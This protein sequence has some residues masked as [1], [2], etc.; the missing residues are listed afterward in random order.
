MTEPKPGSAAPR[1]AWLTRLRFLLIAWVVLYHLDLTLKVHEVLP[2]L[3]PVLL[4]GYLG[5]DGFFLL[6]GFALWLGYAGRPPA[7]ARGVGRFLL[8]RI[9]KIWPLHA[10]AL[11]GLAA[12]VALASASGAAIRH[13]ERFGA[14]DF[15]LQLLLVNAW[16]T[17]G[18]HA[19]NYPS[20][21][22]SAIF[23]G[24]L[25]FPPLLRAMLRLPRPAVPAVALATLA[26]LAALSA[27]RPGIG[28]NWTIHLGL[29]RFGLEFVLGLALARLA[30]EGRL[31]G[32]SWMLPGAAL[33]LC[34]GLLLRQD[35]LAATGL[36]G[37]IAGLWLLGRARPEAVG[38][39]PDLLLR[40]GEAS[41]GVYLCWIFVEAALVGLLRVL[42]PGPAG[43]VALMLGALGLNLLLGWFAWRFVEV[44]AQRLIL[45]LL[46]PGS[47][48][49]LAPAAG[50]E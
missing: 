12:L 40:L 41:F 1:E 31:P 27:A 38:A 29:L 34:A 18:H 25:A 11:L 24:Y 33:T 36:A 7:G 50:R 14:D 42:E 46:R 30:T 9:A 43:R 10:L 23:A 13:P 49:A 32:A 28:L 5:V 3:R 47:R 2:W 48:P 26:G 39:R 8:S 17:T 22:L 44:P 45:G 21:A 20:W 4:K 37:A 6:S 15:L 16:E 35:A 19:W